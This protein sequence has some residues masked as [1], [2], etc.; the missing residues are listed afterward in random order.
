MFYN[1]IRNFDNLESLTVSHFNVTISCIYFQKKSEP[2]SENLNPFH[3]QTIEL[4]EPESQIQKY[5]NI[6]KRETSL[7]LMEHNHIKAFALITVTYGMFEYLKLLF[8]QA[9]NKI[10]K[11]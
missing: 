1:L 5:D 4:I 11:F 10:F 6:F 7:A 3:I 9:F 8:R 2:E